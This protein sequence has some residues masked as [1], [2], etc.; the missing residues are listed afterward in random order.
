M[1]NKELEIKL[2]EEV[3]GK[4]LMEHAEYITSQDRESGSPGEKRAAEYFRSV[5][6]ELGLDVDIQYVEN[7]ISLPVF[8]SLTLQDGTELS[9]CITHS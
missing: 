6:G 5:M 3:D 1:I 9:S 8:G 2:M 4:K 7:Y